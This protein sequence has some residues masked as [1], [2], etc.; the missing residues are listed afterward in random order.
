MKKKI[1]EGKK[2]AGRR[3]AR[4]FFWRNLMYRAIYWIADTPLPE[5]ALLSSFIMSRWWLNSD[6]SYPGEI[7]L[8]IIMFGIIATIAFYSYR[9]VFGKGSAAHLA[10]ILVSYGFYG[11][12]F[13]HD[14]KAGSTALKVIPH[15]FRTELSESILLGILMILLAGALAWLI[16]WTLHRYPSLQRAQ[17]YKVL[18]FAVVFIFGI[19][20]VRCVGRYFEMHKEMSYHYP[21]PSFAKTA[22][23]ISKPD[24]YY[25][26]FDRYGN[27]DQLKNNFNF[28]NSD[29]YNFL[30]SKGFTNRKDAFANYPFTMSSVPS[31]MAMDYFPQFEQM[32]G[33]D[34]K[35]QSAYPYRSVLNNP[36]VAQLLKQNGYRYNN[37]S[38]WWDFTRVG[39]NADTDPTESFR[40]RVFGANIY[41]TDLQRDTVHKSILSP[42][43]KKGVSV[44]NKTVLKYDL[45][46]NPRENFEAQM[47]ALRSIAD[48]ADK[49]KPSYS[50]AHILAPHPPYLFNADGSWPSYDGEANDNGVDEGVKYVNETKYVNTQIKAV[51]G[52][53]QSKDPNAVIVIQ[54]DE[55]P[56]PKQFRGDITANNY[57]N[58]LK[59]PLGKMQQKFGVFASYYLPNAPDGSAKEIN[60]SVNTFRV[61]LNSYLGY[62]MPLLPD[63]N[64]SSG[65]KFS[66]YNY[67]LVT[68]KLKNQ[69]APAECK[70]YK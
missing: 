64:F 20:A 5:I 9:A 22:A 3:K 40:L 68:D 21:A 65:D 29:I 34:G 7:W 52:D 36:P 47:G 39:I 31:T 53:I 8:P 2:S 44:G 27:E 19:Q 50:F 16:R 35:W 51:V 37:L 55:G 42:W 33:E 56:Y 13:I 28:D 1:E 63:C 66:I 6:F 18:L 41:L 10:A 38:S 43:L 32:F 45:D 54:A 67:T 30:A 46:R 62:N 49:S 48:R 60:S 17:P 70:N 57:Y 61:V 15:S 14:S 25:L 23:A 11:Y 12:S 58:P 24:I 26:L 59:L 69:P 4:P